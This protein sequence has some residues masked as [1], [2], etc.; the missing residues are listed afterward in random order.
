MSNEHKIRKIYRSCP[1]LIALETLTNST[2]S[3]VAQYSGLKFHN[4]TFGNTSQ[5]FY[6]AINEAV[7][8]LNKKNINRAIVGATNCS[9]ILLVF[10][11]FRSHWL[12]SRMEGIRWSWND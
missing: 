11:E 6:M 1:P 2:M 9:G 5:S 8:M 7:M 3:Y 12:F 4:A 10:D